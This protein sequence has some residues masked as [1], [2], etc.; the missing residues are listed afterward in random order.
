MLAP[1]REHFV[2][3]RCSSWLYAISYWAYHSLRCFLMISIFPM[4][5]CVCG[6]GGLD[7]VVIYLWIGYEETLDA[8]TSPR[9]FSSMAMLILTIRNICYWAYHYLRYFMKFQSD[10]SISYFYP[11]FFA[12]TL[13]CWS[14]T[15][16]YYAIQQQKFNPEKKVTE[17]AHPARFSPDDKFSSQRVGMKKRFGI[18][19][20]DLPPT[21]EL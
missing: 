21:K 14:Y 2:Q 1:V 16:Q 12:S 8:G 4:C 17:S 13:D 9:T 10:T 18:Y 5:V 11:L 6:V 3:W 7:D 15:W 20:P 19:L